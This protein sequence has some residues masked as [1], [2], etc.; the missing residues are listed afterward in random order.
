MVFWSVLS[1]AVALAELL[2]FLDGFIDRAAID[3][4]LIQS[5]AL[6]PVQRAQRD[7]PLVIGGGRGS[8]MLEKSPQARDQEE[9]A[10]PQLWRCR[11]RNCYDHGQPSGED[12]ARFVE[13]ARHG[14]L[15]LPC[16]IK[17]SGETLGLVGSSRPVMGHLRLNEG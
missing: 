1:E 12:A 16:G 8:P 11:R 3:A 5:V 10:S 17:P 7:L 4:R 14:Q 13:G 6:E 15:A 9:G 2:C